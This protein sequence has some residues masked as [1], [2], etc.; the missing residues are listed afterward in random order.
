MNDNKMVLTFDSA[1]VLRFFFCG[2]FKLFMALFAL[3]LAFDVVSCTEEARL[4]L[5]GSVMS[6]DPCAVMQCPPWLH[7]PA[8][9]DCMQ[10]SFANI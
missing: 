2:V 8:L 1:V 5:G 6:V 10:M 7:R 4:S 9:H 3:H